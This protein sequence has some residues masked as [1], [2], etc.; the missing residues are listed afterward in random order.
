[1]AAANESRIIARQGPCCGDDDAATKGE[2]LAAAAALP[3]HPRTCVWA[4]MQINAT[5]FIYL[6]IYNIYL[7]MDGSPI[8]AVSIPGS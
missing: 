3:H 1:M 6:Y 8:P 7:M 4:C 2:Q 5:L